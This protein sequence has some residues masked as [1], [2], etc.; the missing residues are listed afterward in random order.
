[1][2]DKLKVAGKVGGI[3]SQKTKDYNEME[4]TL[5]IAQ[6]NGGGGD[7]PENNVEAILEG[8]KLYPDCREIIMIADN[9]ATPRDLAL[10]KN[11]KIPVHIILCGSNSGVNTDYLNMAMK[12]GGSIHTIEKDIVKLTGF[13]EGQVLEIN[14]QKFQ[15]KSGEFRL[16]N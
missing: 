6:R 1:M 12:T 3:Y 13:L 8:I 16:L 2:N 4:N 7:G 14:N 15:I 5:K 11:V 9:W 10:L